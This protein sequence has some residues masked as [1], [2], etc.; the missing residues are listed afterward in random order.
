MG[1]VPVKVP[2]EGSET[3]ANVSASPFGSLPFSTMGLPRLAPS[4]R[5]ILRAVGGAFGAAKELPAVAAQASASNVLRKVP[6]ALRA[7]P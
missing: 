6:T 3:T 4:V 2:R 5:A 7:R 1:A